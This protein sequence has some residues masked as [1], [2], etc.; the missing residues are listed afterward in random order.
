MR[1]LFLSVLLLPALA[2]SWGMDGHRV[3]ATIAYRHLEPE[4][5][6]KID[7]ITLVE[8][9]A[10]PALSRFL[11]ASV[12][13]DFIA[14]KDDKRTQP[15]HFID[16][17]INGTHPLDP[18]NVVWAIQ[19][20][21]KTLEN[22]AL[23]LHVRNRALRFLV[24]FVGDVHQPLHCA[25]RI[26]SL[27][28]DGDRGGNA[29]YIHTRVANNLHSYWDRGLGLLR[30]HGKRLR[31]RQVRQMAHDIELRY[32]PSLFKQG[33]KVTGPEK[34]ARESYQ[35]AKTFAYQVDE[36][37]SLDYINK[38]QVIVK[39][40]LALAGYRLAALLNRLLKDADK[41]VGHANDT[42]R[43]RRAHW[44]VDCASS[45]R[46]ATLQGNPR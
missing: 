19:E 40:R 14:H 20:N 3:I 36:S 43:R 23:S 12:W 30:F 13:P 34:W 38:G 9:E 27:M 28:P 46:V 6:A 21:T 31:A 26:T 8:D 17:P 7:A 33:L 29:F 37:P 10:Y 44:C 22:K 4:V 39:Q 32:P 45:R 25:T 15:W 5:K 41:E 2:F 1:I 24:H 42:H 35:L 16:M 18:H 11:Y